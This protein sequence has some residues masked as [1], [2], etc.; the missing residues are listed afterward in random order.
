MADYVVVFCIGFSILAVWFDWHSFRIPNRFILFGYFMAFFI[1]MLC[2]DKTVIQRLLSLINGACCPIF[3]MG[4][5]WII[6]GIGAGDVK[7]LSVLGTVLGA[8]EI[9]LCCMIALVVGAF[10]G[11]VAKMRRKKKIHFSIAILISILIYFFH[12]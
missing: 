12:L 3:F 9:L 6:G 11:I 2:V 7:L 5:I 10:I 1:Q 8:R 4:L